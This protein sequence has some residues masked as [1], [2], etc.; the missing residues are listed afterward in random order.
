M[1]KKAQYFP[2]S[3]FFSQYDIIFPLSKIHLRKAILKYFIDKSNKSCAVLKRVY[4]EIIT[5]PRCHRLNMFINGVLKY[6]LDK[7]FV[8]MWQNRYYR[9]MMKM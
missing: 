8:A 3:P 4:I 5:R 7:I 9:M 1:Q 2:V 6:C